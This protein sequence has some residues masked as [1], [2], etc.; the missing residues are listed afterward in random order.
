[1]FASKVD[2]ITFS[3]LQ[4]LT[5]AMVNGKLINQVSLQ[6]MIEAASMLASQLELNKM[7]SWGNDDWRG[8][9]LTIPDKI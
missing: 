2:F 1:M 4:T 3:S 6:K 5:A 8:E 7:A 9:D